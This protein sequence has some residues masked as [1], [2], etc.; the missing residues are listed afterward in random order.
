MA[1]TARAERAQYDRDTLEQLKRELLVEQIRFYRAENQRR[2]REQR[3]QEFELFLAR[4]FGYPPP[5][6]RGR[7]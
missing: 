5:R 6:R 2:D 4:T 3:E 7:P 1:T